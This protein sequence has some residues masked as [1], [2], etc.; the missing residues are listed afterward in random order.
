MADF[1]K[2]ANE[3]GS[4][5]LRLLRVLEPTG[6]GLRVFGNVLISERHY[7]EDENELL[8]Y[9]ITP[10]HGNLNALLNLKHATTNDKLSI[11]KISVTVN[12]RMNS[13]DFGPMQGIFIEESI[14][15]KGITTFLVN[16]L[17]R[18]LKKNFPDYTINAFE[19]VEHENI[20]EQVRD[21][22]NK[23]LEKFGFS[24]NY[25][26]ITNRNGTMRAKKPALLKEVYNS[27]RIEELDIEQYVL[28]LINDRGKME[29]D[30]NTL[31]VE[32]NSRGEEIF[33]GVTKSEFV[34]YTLIGCALVIILMVFLI[35]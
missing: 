14:R 34:K 30:I 28:G 23:F 22:R 31:K 33:K 26:D 3:Y 19:I 7:K 12:H 35:V 10:L 29:T 27:E 2:R 20:T 17:I 6:S 1:E 15:G 11:N 9:T 4:T 16:E 5:T 8:S 32:L 24:L 25:T 21:I 18:W 13:I